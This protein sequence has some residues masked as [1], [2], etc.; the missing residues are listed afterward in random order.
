[1]TAVNQKNFSH[2]QVEEGRRIK[3][4]RISQRE[5]FYNTDRKGKI[6]ARNGEGNGEG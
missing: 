1:M 4:R 3:G 2:E 6:I 5:G